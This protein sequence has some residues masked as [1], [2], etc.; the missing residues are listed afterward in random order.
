MAYLTAE[1]NRVGKLI[2]PIAANGSEEEEKNRRDR[3][4][5]KERSLA[6]FV[7]INPGKPWYALVA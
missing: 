7:K 1:C 6:R 3:K 5:C 2:C 4:E